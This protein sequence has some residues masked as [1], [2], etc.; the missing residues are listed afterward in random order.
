MKEQLS[1]ELGFLA[2]RFGHAEGAVLWTSVAVIAFAA[3]FLVAGVL[4]VVELRPLV[5]APRARLALT[6]LHLLGCLLFSS[7]ALLFGLDIDRRHNELTAALLASSLVI[8]MPLHIY[9]G[10][11]RRLR[12][13]ERSEKAGG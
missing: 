12:L 9:L 1:R 11:L 7:A 4:R 6:A 3:I 5:P 13:A 8:L 10:L 2:S